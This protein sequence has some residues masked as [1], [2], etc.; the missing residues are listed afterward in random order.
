MWLGICILIILFLLYLS[1]NGTNI[2]VQKINKITNIKSSSVKSSG[3]LYFAD[4]VMC[5]DFYGIVLIDPDVVTMNGGE[6]S[7]ILGK[8]G[9]QIILMPTEQFL[10]QNKGNIKV[11]RTKAELCDNDRRRVL[12]VAQKYLQMYKKKEYDEYRDLQPLIFVQKILIDAG[13]S[14]YYNGDA[15]MLMDSQDLYFG[16]ELDSRTLNMMPLYTTKDPVMM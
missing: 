15:F 1:Y 5:D 14:S 3:Q 11:R 16:P 6:Y 13:I 8:S 9:G 2:I 12:I 10:Q 4:I 7:L